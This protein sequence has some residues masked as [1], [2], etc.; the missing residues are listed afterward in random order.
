VKVILGKL[1]G[2]KKKEQFG[3]AYTVLT[4]KSTQN[5]QIF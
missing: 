2:K 3:N 1:L 5:L 4:K